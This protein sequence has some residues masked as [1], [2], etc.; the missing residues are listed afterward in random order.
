MS[1]G[2]YEDY[3]CIRFRYGWWLVF[4]EFW[5]GRSENFDGKF[6]IIQKIGK[7]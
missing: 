4:C 1:Q 7:F 6:K 2:E 3:C 5:E